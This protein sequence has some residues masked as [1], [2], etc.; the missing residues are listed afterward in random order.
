MLA[1]HFVGNMLVN[2]ISS[3]TLF[4]FTFVLL[5]VISTWQGIGKQ[6]I[7][8]KE[9]S[10]TSDWKSRFF[11]LVEDGLLYYETEAPADKVNYMYNTCICTM[12]MYYTCA[13]L[14]R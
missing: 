4:I 6:G 9:G 14:V 1:V 3:L 7:L 13:S 8:H 5:F 2:I 11:R 10:K 12:Y